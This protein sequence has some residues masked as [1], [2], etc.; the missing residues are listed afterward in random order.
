MIQKIGTIIENL[1]NNKLIYKSFKRNQQYINTTSAYID[2]QLFHR[3]WDI[4]EIGRRQI[5]KQNYN[6]GFPIPGSRNK[7]DLK[8]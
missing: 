4:I 3:N 6:A 5:Y 1:G 2:G 7:L 8:V